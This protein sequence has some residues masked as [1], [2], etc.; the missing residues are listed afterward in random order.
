[1]VAKHAD[2][3][4]GRF[5]VDSG[6]NPMLPVPVERIADHCDLGIL[7]EPISEPLGQ[8]IL[9]GLD[10][11]GRLIIFNERRRSLFDSTPFLYNTVLAHELGHWHLHVDHTLLEYPLLPG[12]HRPFQFVC[13]RGGDAWEERH[14]AQFMSHLLLPRYLLSA[15]LVDVEITSLAG[16]YH[17]RDRYQVTITAMRIALESLGRGYVDDDGRVHPSKAE[18]HGQMRLLSKL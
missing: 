15:G 9:A 3:L 1:M 7:W 8:T 11:T 16:M 18:F 13:Q 6:W 17:F 5:A 12:F 2:R 4:L 10:P 14:A